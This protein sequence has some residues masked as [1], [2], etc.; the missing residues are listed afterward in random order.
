MA[1]RTY[2]DITFVNLYAEGHPSV[3]MD[4]EDRGLATDYE[5]QMTHQ[6]RYADIILAC[7]I[8]TSS[9]LVI[10]GPAAGL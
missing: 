9:S 4:R 6:R 5:H 3:R 7:W 2:A 8:W 10:S 1:K